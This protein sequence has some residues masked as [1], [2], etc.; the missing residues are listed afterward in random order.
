MTEKPN[1]RDQHQLSTLQ[2]VLLQWNDWKTERQGQPPVVHLTESLVTV[3]WL[4]NRT[5]GTNTRCPPYREF[6]YSEMT[7]KPN[8]RD[9]HQVSTLQRV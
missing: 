3:K 2:R 1:G 9:Q 7:E 6:S 5:A 8:G 4:K